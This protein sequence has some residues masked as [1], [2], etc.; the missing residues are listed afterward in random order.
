MCLLS[1]VL[2]LNKPLTKI[3]AAFIR[4]SDDD[5][6]VGVDSVRMILMNGRLLTSV[7]RCHLVLIVI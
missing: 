3:A 6:T 7:V 5:K 2:E 4:G 1:I